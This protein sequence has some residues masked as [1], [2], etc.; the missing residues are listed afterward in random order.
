MAIEGAKNTKW[1]VVRPFGH[2]YDFEIQ[3]LE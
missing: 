2:F 3:R 1:V